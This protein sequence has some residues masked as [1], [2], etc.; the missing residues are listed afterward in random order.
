LAQ[1]FGYFSKEESERVKMVLKRYDLPTEY[2]IESEELFYDHF[3]LDKKSQNNSI[4]FIVPKRIGE[5]LILKDAK[6]EP[7]ITVLKKFKI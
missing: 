1:E 6:K 7:V 2:G 3:F 5:F 4:T